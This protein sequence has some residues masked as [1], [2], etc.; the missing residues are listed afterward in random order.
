MSTFTLQ[1]AENTMKRK[2]HRLRI[3]FPSSPSRQWHPR[4]AHPHPRPACTHGYR[5]AATLGLASRHLL[6]PHTHTSAGP[7]PAWPVPLPSHRFL[8]R[9]SRLK[10]GIGASAFCPVPSTPPGRIPVHGRK[11]PHCPPIHPK[12]PRGPGLAPEGLLHPQNGSLV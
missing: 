2:E 12:L 7:L 6:S 9:R 5:T 10:Y 11:Q 4:P 8:G 3:G 1:S